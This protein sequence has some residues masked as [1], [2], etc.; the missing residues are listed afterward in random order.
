MVKKKNNDDGWGQLV[1]LAGVLVF[2]PFLIVGAISLSSLKRQYLNKASAQQV[3]DIRR[4]GPSFIAAGG[5][6]IVCVLIV[7]IGASEIFAD[8]ELT[9]SNLALAA[10]AV[11]GGSAVGILGGV[12][13]ARH[14]SVLY[15]GVIGDKENDVVHFS[16]DMQSYSVMDYVTL[17]F[18]KEFC[19]IDSV[20]LS[21][22]EK[23]TRGSRGKDLYIHGSFGSRG[24]TMSNKQK[25]D[26]C[27]AMI[28][29]MTGKKGLLTGEVEG[30]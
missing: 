9:N 26:E 27:M 28:M 11:L 10:L 16:Y 17:R 4:L 5:M 8:K 23:I 6:M 29:S 12:I 15:L 20:P 2:L 30:F 19:R 18:L 1:I 25:R 7:T 3:V 21:A 14:I 24:I 13:M 22:I